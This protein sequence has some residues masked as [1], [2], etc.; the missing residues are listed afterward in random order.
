MTSAKRTGSRFSS[1]STSRG[2]RWRT[3]R[4]GPSPALEALRIVRQ[5]VEGLEAAWE[6]HLVHR[7]IKPSN[8]LLDR[9]GDVH[10][11]DFGLAKSLHAEV[12]A[13]VTAT[14][15]TAGTPHYLS[16][17]QA[18]GMPVDFRSDIYSLGIVLYEMLTG[19]RPFRE[20]RPSRSSASISTSRCLRCGGAGLMSPRRSSRWWTR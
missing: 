17:E 15:S 18:R 11:A 8:L 2:S 19:T 14:G 12:D 13:T 7:D 5:A 9:R 10:V 16:P 4:A 20:R 1:W 3:R 6:H